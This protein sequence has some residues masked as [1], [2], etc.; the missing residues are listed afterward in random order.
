MS[1]IHMVALLLLAWH[2]DH[3]TGEPAGNGAPRALALNNAAF[4]TSQRWL[5]RTF[6]ACTSAVDNFCRGPER[7]KARIA[8]L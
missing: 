2:A 6:K 1:C 8:G 3:G 7:E 5:W 4:G